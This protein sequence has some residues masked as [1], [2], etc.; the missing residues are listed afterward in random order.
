[1]PGVSIEDKNLKIRGFPAEALGKREH[2]HKIYERPDAGNWI[3]CGMFSNEMRR[4]MGYQ[5]REQQREVVIGGT[6]STRM[7]R[8][9]K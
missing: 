6:N 4:K 1:M 8:N 5:R 2:G 3:R 7:C 9:R